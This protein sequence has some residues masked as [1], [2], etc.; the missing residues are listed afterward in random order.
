MC[1]AHKII[2]LQSAMLSQ[3]QPLENPSVCGRVAEH[4]SCRALRLALVLLVPKEHSVEDTFTSISEDGLWFWGPMKRQ[5][6]LPQGSEQ[7]QT[8]VLSTS[9]NPP[10]GT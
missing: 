9:E 10:R 2:W 4:F 5:L 6:G 3:L 8:K 7:P 1:L